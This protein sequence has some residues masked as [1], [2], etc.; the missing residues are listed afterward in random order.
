MTQ[1][2]PINYT[3]RLAFGMVVLTALASCEMPLAEAPADAPPEPGVAEATS[4]GPD[5]APPGSCW[6]R[7]VS[8]AVVETITEKVQVKPAEISE[9]GTV[10]ALPV[11]R[12]ESRQQ[13]ITPRQDNW[14]ETPCSDVLTEEFV[15]SLQRALAARGFYGGAAL[16]QM[17]AATRSAIRRYQVSAG[18]PDSEVLSLAAARMLGLIAVPRTPPVEPE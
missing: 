2:F 13:I 15:A 12:D 18:G 14:F 1:T 17:D 6:G 4:N 16:G 11:Y 9:A 8:P 5:G 7:T 3:S 10:T